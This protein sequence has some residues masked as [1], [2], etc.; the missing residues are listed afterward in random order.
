MR[1]GGFEEG[2]ESRRMG[3]WQ[4]LLSLTARL[5]TDIGTQILLSTPSIFDDYL[6]LVL[7]S[8]VLVTLE[9]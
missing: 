7:R 9:G 6:W 4:Y 2:S 8:I 1:G 3:Y 5:G